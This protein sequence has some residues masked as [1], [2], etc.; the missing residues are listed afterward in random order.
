MNTLFRDG[1]TLAIGILAQ[2]VLIGLVWHNTGN[3]IYL[4]FVAFLLVLAPARF[5]CMRQ[6]N[7]RPSVSHKQ[8]RARENFYIIQSALHGGALGL[9][10]LI[11]LYRADST[12]AEL[13]GIAIPLATATAIA[14]RNYGS[15]R[16]VAILIVVITFP[17]AIGVILRGDFHS[18][19]LGV[20]TLPYLFAIRSYAN[21]VRAVLFKA[22]S[23]EN[24]S[25]KIAAQFDRALNTMPHG[26][27]MLGPD[28]RV[29]VGNAEAARMLALSS[30]DRI[31]GR[32]IHA[33]LTRGVAAGLLSLR[34]RRCLETQLTRAL[35]DGGDGKVLLGLSNGRYLEFST[36][37]GSDQLGVIT[38]E[39]VTAR[40]EVEEKVRSMARFDNLT[41]LVNRAY[42]NELVSGQLAGGDRARKCALVMLDL[43][44]FKS[45][46]DSLGHP[47]GDGMLYAVAER[48]E[49]IVGDTAQVCRFGGDEFVLYFDRVES[50]QD[51][52]LVLEDL[53]TR[54]Q[55]SVDISGHMLHI[56]ASGGAVV[57]PVADSGVD[58]LIV[59]ADL[60]LYKAK[61]LGKK[62]W[63]L[64]KPAMDAAFRD[65]QQLKAD[66]R[67]A[68]EA[69][70][71]RV[72]YQPIVS[73][74]TM[75]I[76]G[77]EALCRWDHPEM[78]P[79]SPAVFIPLA[80]EMGLISEISAFV[81]D[82]ACQE[83]VRWPAPI[84]VSVNLSAVDFRNR[85]VVTAVKGALTRAK[86]A[87]ERL[88]IEVTETALLDDKAM[89]Q[90]F[91]EELKVIGVRIALDDFGT[92][93]SSLSYL[94]KLPLD[95]IKI[96][97]SFLADVTQSKRSLDL[98]VGMVNLSRPL[99]LAVT[100]EGVETFDQLQTLALS[101]QP[102][103]LQGF[104]FGSALTPS[105]IATMSGTVWPFAERLRKS[106]LANAI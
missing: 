43:D 99:G 95:K 78:G 84:T 69:R 24:R 92:G 25:Q 97:R 23:A 93:Y 14:G 53:F 73:M 65:R 19:A 62:T 60:A 77:C 33:L 59:R 28:T 15:M 16:M 46:N 81:L 61:E 40:I 32:S 22:I 29:V 52:D 31:L 49:N 38:F 100:V 11:A 20:L 13:A 74:K 44:D 98:L 21:N 63:C 96:D 83:C 72:V 27:V 104:L 88:E 94:H 87:P 36:R 70:A 79:I 101:V 68:I 6:I 30:P 2:S 41:G 26:L 86:L 75:R 54:L 5:L 18:V 34:D 82:T 89:T 50:E 80:E 12:F 76:S 66:L 10:S 47:M 58:A 71:M 51:F 103:L 8:A 35:R 67:A 90:Q 7:R 17:M 85:S 91:I 48:L 64:F 56:Q 3:P 39:D 45:V 37:E 57:A 1:K 42:F 105:G 102:D 4:I 55:G 9:F 106:A